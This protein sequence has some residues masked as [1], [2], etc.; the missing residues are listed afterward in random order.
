MGIYDV[1]QEERP[2]GSITNEPD[3]RPELEAFNAIDL[4]YSWWE[5][6]SAQVS[7]A[8]PEQWARNKL[9]L[10]N[11]TWQAIDAFDSI[12][13]EPNL[14]GIVDTSSTVKTAAELNEQY[15]TNEFKLPMA[16]FLAEDYLK[17]AQARKANQYIL[18]HDGGTGFGTTLLGSVPGVLEP[19]N[20]VT[21]ALMGPLVKGASL[22]KAT[23]AIGAE[24]LASTAIAVKG[25]EVGAGAEFSKT[26]VA[27]GTALGT[28]FGVALHKAPLKNIRN[29]ENPTIK[30]ATTLAHASEGTK[31]PTQAI[32]DEAQVRAPMEIRNTVNAAI[33]AIAPSTGRIS[34]SD[35][36]DSY[37]PKVKPEAIETIQKEL[38]DTIKSLPE[39]SIVVFNKTNDVLEG[40][41]GGS[42]VLGEQFTVDVNDG[43]KASF[44]KGERS[45][46]ARII[47][48]SSIIEVDSINPMTAELPPTLQPIFDAIPK[49]D[50]PAIKT[51]DLIDILPDSRDKATALREI[52][53]MNN[54]KAVK[55]KNTVTDYTGKVS[56]TPAA[57]RALTDEEIDMPKGASEVMEKVKPDEAFT[58]PN[59]IKAAEDFMNLPEVDYDPK[60]TNINSVVDEVQAS[61]D[62]KIKSGFFK[63]DMI[64]FLD[65]V[66]EEDLNFQ[67]LE[68]IQQAYI[69]CQ[70]G[71]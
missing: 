17:N 10:R 30:E 63:E 55:F 58:K 12:N 11:Y 13:D 44:V 50:K 54:G 15:K 8:L 40:F 32:A 2:F 60:L 38:E 35:I 29:K 49:A 52:S 1:N 7:E 43:A 20:F 26:D 3:P 24:S 14:D 18:E 22:A 31:T 36:V 65:A 67:N 47:P 19:V 25:A 28:A 69:F 27:V 66:K 48:K 37:L 64:E 23:A 56:D 4:P 68:K 53:D 61:I 46:E 39:D 5:K 6:F 62:E 41:E 57:S 34:T 51:S 42:P 9:M 21:S 33:E 70:R 59:D 16:D 45:L 71:E